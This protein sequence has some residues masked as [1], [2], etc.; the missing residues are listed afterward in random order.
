MKIAAT[1][2]A[3]ADSIGPLGEAAKRLKHIRKAL[4]AQR[5]S[6]TDEQYARKVCE[7]RH[8]LDSIDGQIAEVKPRA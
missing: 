3:T 7:L 6:M 8:I 2:A 4:K 5:V 1:L